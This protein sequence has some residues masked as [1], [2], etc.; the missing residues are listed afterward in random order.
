MIHASKTVDV[1]AMT[2][3]TASLARVPRD[4]WPP[5]HLGAIVGL[6]EV[7]DCTKEITSEVW[8]KP[9]QFGWYVRNA[10]RLA[11]PLLYRGAQGLFEVPDALILSKLDEIAPVD[12]ST[13]K[14]PPL[15]SEE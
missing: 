15:K 3:F 11:V 8:H 14:L 12:D 13:P 10:G 4:K 5:L 1:E 6:V 9:R 7:V 2:N